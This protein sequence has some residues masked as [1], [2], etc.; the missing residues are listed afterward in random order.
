MYRGTQI[1]FSD[2]ES[3]TEILD[4]TTYG[5]EIFLGACV[6]CHYYT[7]YTR[8]SC[9]LYITNPNPIVVY[10]V[11]YMPIHGEDEKDRFQLAKK[12]IST[13]LHKM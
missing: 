5:V 3:K 2:I 13:F 9:P 8:V 7:D 6:S 12:N 11:K 4:D 10:S 1:F